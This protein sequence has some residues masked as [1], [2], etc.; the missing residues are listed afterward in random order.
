MRAR[1]GAGRT[2][3]AHPPGPLPARAPDPAA[4]PGPPGAGAA[5]RDG[6]GTVEKYRTI[7]LGAK[8]QKPGRVDC[9]AEYAGERGMA[10]ALRP[11]AAGAKSR[12]ESRLDAP[13]AV[14]ALAGERFPPGSV[15]NHLDPQL[16]AMAGLALRNGGTAPAGAGRAWEEA[17][18]WRRGRSRARKLGITTT[19]WRTELSGW[20]C[21]AGCGGS[22]S[23]P[24]GGASSTAYSRREAPERERDDGP[25]R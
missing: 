9:P 23:G 24:R 3:P 15:A 22:G 12:G 5:E 21:R 1:G 6:A 8:R 18:R 14:S 2:V 20:R 13:G 25:S 10:R 4:A 11:A 17:T 16:G 19:K 7:G